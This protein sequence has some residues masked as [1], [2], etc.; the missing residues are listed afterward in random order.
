MVKVSG[1]INGMEGIERVSQRFQN[2]VE[3]LERETMKKITLNEAVNEAATHSNPRL[4]VSDS[5]SRSQRFI[6][7]SRSQLGEIDAF[8]RSIV[9]KPLNIK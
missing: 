1:N 8:L 2:G 4:V 5:A 6:S 7:K 3:I 9:R